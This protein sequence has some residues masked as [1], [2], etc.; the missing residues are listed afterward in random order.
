MDSNI[1]ITRTDN[2]VLA[3]L[4]LTYEDMKA[5]DIDKT[6]RIH[7]NNGVTWCPL[8]PKEC[9][10]LL[11]GQPVTEGE[12]GCYW[13]YNE[14]A[15]EWFWYQDKGTVMY[16]IVWDE[17]DLISIDLDS[18]GIK[19]KEA[20]PFAYKVVETRVAS[21][22]VFASCPEEAEAILDASLGFGNYSDDSIFQDEFEFQ[23][24]NIYVVS[25]DKTPECWDRVLKRPTQVREDN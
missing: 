1:T 7:T 12:E 14:D 24:Y 23:G 9:Y 25:T 6:T 21:G 3:V 8:E 22:Y 2:D 18:A 5:H 17:D 19:D 20:K 10:S 13:S 15:T 4:F 16:Q 11:V